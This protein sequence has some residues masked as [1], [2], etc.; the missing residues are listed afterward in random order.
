MSL[1]VIEIDPAE[2][3]NS[4]RDRLLRGP[5]ERTVLLLP[6]E[7]APLSGLD[8][9]LLRRLADRERLEVGLVTVDGA[10]ARQARAL[11]LPAFASLGLAEHFRPGW[12]RA[13]R[14]SEHVGFAPGQDRQP[15][16]RARQG[17]PDPSIAARRLIALLLALLILALLVG[18]LLYALPRAIVTLDAAAPPG[19]VIL[20][21]TADP[22]VTASAGSSIPARELRRELAW[23]ASGAATGDDN[24]DQQR[25]HA[26]ALQ[27]LRAE[28]PA[29]WRA[30][31]APGEVLVENSVD[32][33]VIDASFDP[34][35]ETA[36]LALAV[37]S[38]ALAVHEADIAP[39][40]LRELAGT[41][42]AGFAP[43]PAT[44]RLAVAPG[45]AGAPNGLRVTA[46]A[47]GRAAPDEAAVAAALRGQS[48]VDAKR[49]LAGLPVDSSTVAVWPGWWGDWT[50]RMPFRAGNIRVNLLP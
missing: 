33:E 28:M 6:E 37:A 48:L 26:L 18:V 30:R 35:G 46:Q 21:L 25:L 41:L 4:M 32:V 24:A 45:A 39:I 16:G 38:R 10:L 11:G 2:T 44:L 34:A 36:V 20:D 17:Q 19:Q 49:Y 42:P 3:Y 40:A 23:E 27:G 15:P 31:L 9:V 50:G 12:W 22:A 8:L 13:G 5:R 1:R 47:A 29:Y 43:D 14:R 7:A